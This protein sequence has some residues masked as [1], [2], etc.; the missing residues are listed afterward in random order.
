MLDEN[1]HFSH[2]NS[3]LKFYFFISVIYK[4]SLYDPEKNPSV[5][6]PISLRRLPILHIYHQISDEG[7]LKFGMAFNSIL[8]RNINLKFQIDLEARFKRYV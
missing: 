4:Y 3:P 8:I 2:W 1:W 5:F 7:V 6:Q